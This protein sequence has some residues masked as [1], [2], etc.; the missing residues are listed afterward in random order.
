[1]RFVTITEAEQLALELEALSE[2]RRVLLK[3]LDSHGL[4]ALLTPLEQDELRRMILLLDSEKEL[5]GRRLRAV[6]K[7]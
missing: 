6:Q 3:V 4:L 2:R 5:L 7:R 1:L